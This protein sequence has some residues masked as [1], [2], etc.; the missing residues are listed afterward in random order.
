MSVMEEG[1][2]RDWYRAHRRPVDALLIA[3]L[4]VL[5]AFLGFSGIWSLFSLLPERP[6]P[7][8]TLVT[9]L[10]ACLLVLSKHRAPWFSLAAATA[11][12]AVDLFTVGGLGPLVVLLD[13]LWTAAFLAAPRARRRIL[14]G[15]A[16]SVVV[17]FAVALLRSEAAAPVA[18]LVAVQFGAFVGTDY[19]WAVAVSQANELAELQRQRA[20]EAAAAA[21]RDRAEAVRRERETMARELHD[22]VA[23]HVLVMAIRAEAALSMDA[24]EEAD[25]AALRAVRDAG[26]D[27]HGALRSMI[28]VLRRG[29]GELV[30]TP[31]LGDVEGL[32]ADA[33][34]AGLRIRLSVD[35]VQEAGGTV[36]QAVVRIVREALSNGV[37]HASGAEVDVVIEDRRGSVRVSVLSRGGRAVSTPAYPGGG[38]GLSMLEERVDALGGQF[39]AVPVTGGWEVEAVLPAAA[40]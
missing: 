32:V 5:A 30:P 37:R 34:R 29:D 22:V 31:R 20:D 36:E 23:G 3:L 8:W 11:I 35:D 25:R 40:S 28:A 1:G 33:R 16:I 21:E 38:W 2:I 10:P 19:W 13:V 7:W 4:S 39:R 24:D 26:L 6:S 9:A 15:I 27:A 12:F 18:F 14:I 17:L